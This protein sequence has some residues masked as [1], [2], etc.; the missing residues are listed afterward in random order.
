ML[1][2]IPTWAKPTHTIEM[3]LNMQ[4]QEKL[5]IFS[6]EIG[7]K[8]LILAIFGALTPILGP[9]FFFRKF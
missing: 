4:H 7:Q 6:R 1:A 8:N 9:K 3:S 5:I 2:A